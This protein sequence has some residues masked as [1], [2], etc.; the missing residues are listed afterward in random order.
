MQFEMV[1]GDLLR[2]ALANAKKPP[3]GGG[4]SARLDI[5]RRDGCGGAQPPMP[6]LTASGGVAV[7]KVGI[8]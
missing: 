8:S 1:A 7:W 3:V 2:S 5:A 6:T 4:L